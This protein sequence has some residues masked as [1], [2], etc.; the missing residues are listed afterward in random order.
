MRLQPLAYARGAAGCT[1]AL[2][3]TAFTAAA[4]V[5]TGSVKSGDGVRIVYDVRGKGDTTLLFV[6]C[7]SC[8]RSFWKNQVDAF[9]DRYRVVT[10]DLAGHGESGKDRKNWTVL[11]L[12]DDVRAVADKL[13]LQRIILVGHSMG[14]PV[15][16]EAARLLHGRVIGV[17][18]VDTLHSAELQPPV[19]VFQSIAEKL[20]A[21]FPGMIENF[22]G[23]MFG[24][25]S[26]PS[27]REWVETKAKAANST[28]AVA[29]MLDFPN[30]D[31]KKLFAAAGVPI[32]AIN[33]KPPSAPPTTIEA[34]RKYAD[35]DAVLMDDVGHFIQ[36]ERPREFNEKLAKFAAAVRNR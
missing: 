31:V 10:L 36:L 27:V 11:G 34:N 23:S 9:A 32:R 15:S 22:M 19:G 16:L 5:E 29:L 26:D 21:D 1:F 2:L 24:K 7:W 13:N 6:H 8:D 35:Y 25:T 18:A 17:I 4:A 3:L 28:V 14:G 33:A 20:K 12:A 30:V